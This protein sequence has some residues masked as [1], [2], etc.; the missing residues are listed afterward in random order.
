MTFLTKTLWTT[1]L[2]VLVLITPAFGQNTI[3]PNTCKQIVNA[4]SHGQVLDV[5]LITERTTR[6]QII[7][8]KQDEILQSHRL[9]TG[10]DGV[11]D[12]ENIEII[13]LV[14]GFAGKGSAVSYEITPKVD[15]TLAAGYR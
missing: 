12:G 10:P 13:V 11:F 5:D 15:E 4:L 7:V 8:K 3:E 14:Q 9:I 2:L 6:V 1:I